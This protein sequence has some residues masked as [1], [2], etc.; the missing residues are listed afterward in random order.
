MSNWI[1]IITCSASIGDITVRRLQGSEEDIKKYLWELC[2]MEKEYLIEGTE[3]IEDIVEF[4]KAGT[5]YLSCYNKI[6]EP[7]DVTG[8]TM[9]YIAYPEP[10]VTKL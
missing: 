5:S 2:E 3:K 1:V 9:Q 4:T 6:K 7:F 10:M 8:Y